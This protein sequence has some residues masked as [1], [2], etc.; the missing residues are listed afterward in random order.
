MSKIG[1][2]ITSDAREKKMLA[3]AFTWL[4]FFRL[5]NLVLPYRL[6]KKWV[7]E[8]I[9]DHP[10]IGIVDESVV[11]DVTRSV[12]RCSRLVPGAKCLVKA[13]ATKAVL[14]HYGQQ[15]NIRLGVAK[16]DVSI[17]AHAWVEIDGRIIFGMQAH[18]TRYTVLRP[19]S[20]PSV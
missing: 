16:S 7:S 12:A 19:P 10:S 1:R 15:S 17:A 5:R 9:A 3:M 2:L 14:R 18:N 11:L 20:V 13:L 8:E 4:V 6:T